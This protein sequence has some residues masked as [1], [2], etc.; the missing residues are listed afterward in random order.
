MHALVIERQ[1]KRYCS[2]T[3]VFKH[4]EIDGGF[5]MNRIHPVEF[6]VK[7]EENISCVRL[8]PKWN[9]FLGT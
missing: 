4:C 1:M 9:F 6:V 8:F 5:C 3:K 7:P 2:E